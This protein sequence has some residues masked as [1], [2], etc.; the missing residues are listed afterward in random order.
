M[1]E[2]EFA[3]DHT[4]PCEASPLPHPQH[5]CYR[6]WHRLTVRMLVGLVLI[7]ACSRAATWSGSHGERWEGDLRGVYGTVAMISGKSGSALVPLETLDEAALA[8]VA[9]FLAVK[10]TVS[11]WNVSSSK[12][13]KSLRGRLQV[14]RDGKL[15]AYDPGSRPEPEFYLAYFGAKWCG[16]CRA[17]SPDLVA[18]YRHLQQRWPDRFE[19]I[20]VSSDRDSDEQRSYVRDV[21]MPWPVIK[22]SALGGIDPVERWAGPGI[23]CLVA[24]TRDGDAI[25]HS[26]HGADYV[27]PR[28]VLEEFELL[29]RT[30]DGK[31]VVARRATHRLAV[32]Q[33]LRAVGEGSSSAKPYLVDFDLSHYQTLEEKLLKATL[34]LDE[35]GRVLEAA[36]EPHLPAVLDYQLVHDAGDWLFLPAIKNGKAVAITVMLPLSLKP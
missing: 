30:M 8:R 14:M 6:H 12:V 7:L 29:L 16:P 20:F 22:Y 5:G 26:Y 19:V 28:Q 13:A 3:V 17:F 32:V 23:P 4:V 1:K 11:P 15:V 10:P 27:G 31:S 34:S 2:R 9:D 21:G 33:H 35:G 18:A 24:M 36:F 25:F